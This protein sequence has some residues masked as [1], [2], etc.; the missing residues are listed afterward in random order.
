MGIDQD[1]SMTDAVVL[2]R[3]AE[4]RLQANA[5][6]L[7][8][9]RTK[10]ETQ[11]VVHELEV[12]QIELEMQNAELSIIR[13]EME[14]VLDRYTDLYEF[15]PVGY[16]TLDNEGAVTAA[17]L[18]A[19]G[20]VGLERS[21]LLG[22]RFGLFV[23]PED[24]VLFSDFLGTVFASHCKESCEVR[25]TREGA[26]P[27]FV[28]IEAVVLVAGQ[29]C[30]VAVID[31]TAHRQAEEAARDNEQIYR[32][33]GEAIDYGVWICAPDGRNTYVS[34]SFLRLVG[35]TQEQCSNFGWSAV[36]HPD[37]AEKTMSA[38]QE[39]VRTQ[40]VWDIEQRFRG[41]DGQFHNVLPGEFP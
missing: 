39:C 27:L 29:E 12:H 25:L 13:D 20:L 26:S 41:V 8:P 23:A 5:V 32:A 34:D 37:D 38:W 3:H 28:Q 14:K 16:F 33:I 9:P 30:R 1:K 7:H 22:R 11:R 35:M 4:E 19:A 36:L 2:R 18:T 40:G 17:N 10:A 15:A 6:P 31:M 24:R 21:R